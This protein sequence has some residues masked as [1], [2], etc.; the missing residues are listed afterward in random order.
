[1]ILKDTSFLIS[2]NSL[3]LALSLSFFL[4]FFLSLS[5]SLFLSLLFLPL[6]LFLSISISISLS[7]SLSLSLSFFLFL[8]ISLSFYPELPVKFFVKLLYSTMCGKK[9]Q[10]YGIHI[11]GKCID[12]RHFY[13]CLSPLTTRPQHLVITP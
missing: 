13:S 11:P 3:G 10:I 1:M 6:S 4:S 12:S 7:L 8:S 9:V 2:I 5:L